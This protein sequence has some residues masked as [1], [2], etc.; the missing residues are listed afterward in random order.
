[1][2]QSPE[3]DSHPPAAA[4]KNDAALLWDMLDAAKAITQFVSIKSFRDYDHDRMLRNAVERNIE[5]VG[6][7]AG[8]I[9][10]A[11]QAA[12]PEIPWRGLVVQRDALLA[13]EAAL[14]H[15]RMWV[16]A[17]EFIPY[18]VKTLTAVIPTALQ[19]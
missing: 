5:L 7:A 12:H 6:L 16:A 2:Y 14:D 8:G 3:Q 19:R 17:S 10:P 1:M 15:K 13:G 9:S 18:L 11:F 4:A